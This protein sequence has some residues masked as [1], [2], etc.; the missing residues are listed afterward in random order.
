MDKCLKPFCWPVRIY[1]EDTDAGSVVY[2]ANYL[3][4]MER[5]R[6]EYLRTFNFQQ[7]ELRQH[8]KILFVVRDI[9]LRY[10]TPARFN[11]MITVSAEIINY[12]KAS[13]V[14]HHE[15]F[16]STDEKI[17]CDGEITIACVD[18][19][20]FKPKKMPQPMIMELF[21]GN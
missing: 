17:C 2:Y 13:F 7:D 18:A 20:T 10:K 3:K 8:E 1:Y 5:A 11:D 21:N 9:N 12:K 6:T 16:R 19:D 15:L 14:F 4:Y